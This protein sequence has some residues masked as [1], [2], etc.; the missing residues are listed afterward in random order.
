MYCGGFCGTC[1]VFRG[2]MIAQTAADLKELIDAH[3]L[4]GWV[5]KAEHID[6]SFD[7]FERGLALLGDR[8][9]GPYRQH[10]C[11]DGGGAPCK[12]RPVP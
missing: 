6:F 2:S 9:Q 11:K 5:P 10:P 12:I 1:G 4:A 7:D 3:R 8:K